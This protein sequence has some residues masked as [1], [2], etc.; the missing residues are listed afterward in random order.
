M[1]ILVDNQ[2]RVVVQGITGRDGAFH[3]QQMA[4]YGT[5]VVAGVTPGKGGQDVAGIP[6]YNTVRE[7]VEVETRYGKVKAKVFT[8]DTEKRCAPEY[9]DCLRVARES[10]VPVNEV[11]EETRNA[12]RQSLKD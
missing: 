2:T 3:A 12:F 4:Q 10:G 5:K 11:M 9:D 1:S 8:L 6:V 7:A